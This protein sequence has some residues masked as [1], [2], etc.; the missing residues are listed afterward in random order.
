[1][2][3]SEAFVFGTTKSS[4]ALGRASARHDV[5][6]RR[7]SVGHSSG[8][9]VRKLHGT[10]Y[11]SC[12]NSEGRTVMHWP[13]SP[14][15]ADVSRLAATPVNASSTPNRRRTWPPAQSRPT[16]TGSTRFLAGSCAASPMCADSQSHRPGSIG[17]SR[18]PV[19]KGNQERFCT[20][21]AHI[22]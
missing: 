18:P 14:R 1:M 8:G 12:S 16:R 6:R 13:R 9:T 11:A 17:Q 22:D 10:F 3:G 20:T 21:R 19:C 7:P 5:V 4:R 2:R 15:W